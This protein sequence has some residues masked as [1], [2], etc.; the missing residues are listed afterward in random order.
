MACSFNDDTCYLNNFVN[1]TCT[2]HK[3]LNH[4]K[5]FSE[6]LKWQLKLKF[7]KRPKYHIN[8]ILEQGGKVRI[9]YHQHVQK[10]DE[11]RFCK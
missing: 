11:N 7:Q 5:V 4:P 2:H 9:L 6:F 1:V 3:P 8:V 10:V